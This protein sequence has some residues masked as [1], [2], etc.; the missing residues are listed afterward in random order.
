MWYRG[1]MRRG[2]V[3]IVMLAGCGHPGGAGDDSDGATETGDGSET[4]AS[5]S[6]SGSETQD[7]AGTKFDLGEPDL[8]PD[9]PDCQPAD[10]EHPVPCDDEGPADSFS[11]EVQ[12]SWDNDDG[13]ASSTVTPLVAN[14]TDDNDDGSVDMCD[15]PDVIAVIDEGGQPGIVVLDGATGVE[16]FRIDEPVVP[17][18]TPALGDI[19]GD[20]LIE[21]VA[22]LGPSITIGAWNNDGSKLWEQPFEPPRSLFEN[23]ASIALA[24][25]DHDGDVEIATRNVLLDH[26]GE[27]LWVADEPPL[28]WSAT[29]IADLDGMGDQEILM[30]NVAYRSDGT[31]YWGQDGVGQGFPQV[32]NFDADADPEIVLTTSQGL[33]LLEHDGTVIYQDLRPTDDPAG[34][35]EWLRPATVHDFDGDGEPEFA[36]SSAEHYTVYEADAAIVWSEMV[37]D[38]SGL[39]A[40]TAFDFLGDGVAEAMYADEYSMFVF[41][42]QTGDVLLET[43][44][45]SQ[46]GVEYPVVADVDDDGSAEIIVVSNEYMGPKPP[47]VQ[48]IRDAEDRWIQARRIWNQHTYHVTNVREDGQIPMDEQPSWQDLN[49][50]RTN[51]QLGAG[52][53]ICIP[54][55]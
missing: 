51:A 3:M 50:F 41:D 48:V 7:E 25:I 6:G 4:S 55:G 46:T 52:G 17:F 24:D 33:A 36:M 38:A 49:T 45:S 1:R 14:L 26:E 20:G 11:P 5:E 47:T 18:S 9:E 8:P 43:T 35:L 29:T 12:W 42:G 10:D 23:A 53:S 22:L 44:R 13:T 16:H 54:E 31:E 34:F 30:G 15:T 27:T 19:D 40:G 39:A 28:M 32:A 2:F 37:V 21:I